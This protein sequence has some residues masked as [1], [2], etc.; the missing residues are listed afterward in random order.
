M[1]VSRRAILSALAAAS[2]ADGARAQNR[3]AG[4][5]A[6]APASGPPAP[7]SR[8]G[9]D[10]VIRRARDLATAPFAPASPLPESLNNLDFDAW[11]DIR[12]RPDRALLNGPFKLQLF[13]LGHLFRQAVTVNTIR[14]GLATPIPYTASLFDFGRTKI[15]KPLPVN[16]GFAGFRLHYPLNDPRVYDEVIA[17][18]GA[19]Y[20][21]F[22]GRG[23]RYGLSARAVTVGAGFDGEQFPFFREFWIETPEPNAD[24]ATIYALLDGESLTGAYRFYLW[25]GADS[26]LEVAVNLFPRRPGAHLGFAPLTSM[27]CVGE[28]DHRIHR[29]Y[30]PEMHDSD[31]LLMHTG[32]GEWIWRPLRN[33]AQ[34]VVSA[35]LDHDIRGFGLIQR[36][37]IFDHYQD[38]DLNYEQRPSYWVE[39]LQGW[40]EGR[41][42]L[43]EL[44][45][46]DETNDNIVASWVPRDPV[47]PA[48]GATFG[49]RVTASLD[50]SRLS[51]NGRVVNTFQAQ[52][53]ALGASD[54]AP[55]G[56]NRFIIDFAGGDLPY[57]INDPGLVE[58]VP[59]TSNGR[60]LRS[61]LVPNPNIKGF[62]AAIDVQL[63]PDQ[64]TDLRAFLRSGPRTLTETWIYPWKVD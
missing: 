58:I 21:R 4:S 17:F 39:P 20:F 59:S 47:D 15:D 43:A 11:R 29:D 63:D 35:F 5:S 52:A 22:L 10:D 1:D 12:F 7:P 34:T 56:S 37:R 23:Q 45:T 33:P 28:N 13:H 50:V 42:E 2:L 60:I 48:K 27:F 44:P 18:L 40:G 9:F 3:P 49:Y 26:T 36:D 54:P 53:S 32:D 24:R 41:I 61:F 55:P 25:P 51:P 6:P 30:R 46:G 14:D 62:R 16:L 31:G 8:F 38:L 57:F 64:S 19:S